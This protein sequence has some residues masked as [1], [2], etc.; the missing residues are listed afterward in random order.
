MHAG[1]VGC[2]V[3]GALLHAA[4][5]LPP[6]EVVDVLVVVTLIAT[7]LSGLDYMQAFARRAMVSPGEQP[8]E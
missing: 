5:H 3:D 1:I 6:V 7:L 8:A 4:S 2:E